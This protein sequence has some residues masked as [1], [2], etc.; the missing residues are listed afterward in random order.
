ML[1]A[2][3]R[4]GRHQL[5]VR[6]GHKAHHDA[7]Q[8]EGQRGPSR[9]RLLQESAGQHDPA[10]A[11]HRSEG[12]GQNVPLPQDPREGLFGLG[13]VSGRHLQT[14]SLNVLPL[15]EPLEVIHSSGEF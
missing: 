12:N 6:Q 8:D 3:L 2:D 13:A 9:A 5:G 7:A 11:D 15:L 14:L 10:E 1:S 4:H